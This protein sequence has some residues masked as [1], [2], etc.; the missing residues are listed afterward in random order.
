MSLAGLNR[1]L[2]PREPK[3]A[4]AVMLGVIEDA[5]REVWT[6]A[7]LQEME[8]ALLNKA[9]PVERFV[10]T[11]YALAF[12]INFEPVKP[13]TANRFDAHTRVKQEEKPVSRYA[14]D[15]FD[16]IGRHMQAFAAREAENALMMET[17][18][19]MPEQ[20]TIPQAAIY[21]FETIAL[22]CHDISEDALETIEIDITGRWDAR[23][24]SRWARPA[25]AAVFDDRSIRHHRA[26]MN[27]DRASGMMW[28]NPMLS[29]EGPKKDWPL[30]TFVST[31]EH[32]YHM[33]IDGC[34]ACLWSWV[35]IQDG[36]A[37]RSCPGHPPKGEPCISC[38]KPHVVTLPVRL[39]RGIA[40]A[41]T[42]C[43]SCGYGMVW[44]PDMPIPDRGAIRF[45]DRMK[46]REAAKPVKSLWPDDVFPPPLQ[47]GSSCGCEL[48][49]GTRKLIDSKHMAS[50]RPSAPAATKRPEHRIF[51]TVLDLKPDLTFEEACKELQAKVAEEKRVRRTVSGLNQSAV[52]VRTVNVADQLGYTPDR[53]MERL[54]A[55]KADVER[56]ENDDRR[57]MVDK[58]A[59]WS[60]EYEAMLKE[61][62]YRRLHDGA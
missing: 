49:V 10:A 23:A 43:V 8:A 1:K 18:N 62:K 39:N 47:G 27:G 22:N 12:D 30:G 42:I 41:T 26:V 19:A 32:S 34:G 16:A 48:C 31:R 44:R 24:G 45:E 33:G 11:T 21:D 38:G 50:A 52:R 61:M 58:I 5:K 56:D 6:T 59:V 36:I 51:S 17:T 55:I 60:P 9:D 14:A 29:E 35:N 20:E 4:R 25:S 15:D 2:F 37:P 57:K 3:G 54:L 40:S 7:M 46:K 28:S 53:S 13:R